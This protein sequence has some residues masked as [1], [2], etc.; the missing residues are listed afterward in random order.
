MHSN[1]THISCVFNLATFGENSSLRSL[2][3]ILVELSERWITLLIILASEFMSFENLLLHHQIWECFYFVTCS[4]RSNLLDE[5]REKYPMDQNEYWYIVGSIQKR[6]IF[7]SLWKWP[8]D[9]LNKKYTA[10]NLFMR[11]VS[12]VV[13]MKNQI[14][15]CEM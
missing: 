3:G 10:L 9:F 15:S 4:Q 7:G 8:D 13:S 6:I 11:L 2:S 12:Q 14:F 5:L 1:P